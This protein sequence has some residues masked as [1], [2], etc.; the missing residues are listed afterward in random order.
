MILNKG[1]KF[2]T[3]HTHYHKL[4]RTIDLD[5]KSVNKIYHPSHFWEHG[6]Q[7]ITADLAIHGIDSFRRFKSSLSYFVPTYKFNGTATDIKKYT[8]MRDELCN[9]LGH[10]TKAILA[11]DE[12][13]TGYSQALADYRVYLASERSE[14]PYTDCFSESKI[15]NPI[16]QFKFFGRQF[17][18]SALNYLLGLNF[19]KSCIHELNI[20]TVIE[21]GG[22]FGSL[23]EILLSDA[24]NDIFYTNI[25]IPPTIIFSTYYLDAILGRENVANYLTFQDLKSHNLEILRRSFKAAVIAPWQ[26]EQLDGEVDLFVNFISFQEME[27]DIVTNYLS[28]I[29][30]LKTKYILLRNLREGKQIAKNKK[31]IGVKKPILADDYDEFLFN[32]KLV[33]NV[34]FPYGYKTV[35]G[36]NSELRLYQRK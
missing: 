1:L 24:R 18:R 28:Q 15:G 12:M 13:L 11:L 23:G 7:K 16:E 27:P 31:S 29:D 25:D 5:M 17:S 33:S 6:S 4:L 19:L 35:D 22:G 3:Y 26:I 8:V 21:I 30:R 34:V 32:Y 14:Y 10:D 36:F 9:V 2:M 20:K